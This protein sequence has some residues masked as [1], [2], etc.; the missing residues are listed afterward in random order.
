V[1]WFGLTVAPPCQL[2]FALCLHA[3]IGKRFV[4]QTGIRVHPATLDLPRG[5]SKRAF[6][7]RRGSSIVA[8]RLGIFQGGEE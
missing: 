7:I 1:R 5:G 8:G 3:R 2:S 4:D 6:V